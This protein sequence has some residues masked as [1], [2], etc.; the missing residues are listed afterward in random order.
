MSKPDTDFEWDVHMMNGDEP[1][2]TTVVMATVD[3]ISEY[4]SVYMRLEVLEGMVEM[5]QEVDWGRVKLSIR[6]ERP[7]FIN[8]DGDE[9]LCVAG[10][11]DFPDGKPWGDDDGD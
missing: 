4:D 10:M 3:G 6:D 2:E 8:P 9:S 7:V 5:A 11:P 1:D